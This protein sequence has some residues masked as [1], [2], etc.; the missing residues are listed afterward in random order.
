MWQ[1]LIATDCYSMVVQHVQKISAVRV[2]SEQWVSD[3]LHAVGD[4]L[5]HDKSSWCRWC[6]SGQPSVDNCCVAHPLCS[7]RRRNT[8]L[9]QQSTPRPQTQQQHLTPPTLL[10]QLLEAPTIAPRCSVN[11]AVALNRYAFKGGRPCGSVDNIV[12]KVAEYRRNKGGAELWRS[13]QERMRTS[14]PRP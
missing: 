11:M 8:L 4:A 6:L 1:E 7:P 5:A 12:G 10:H 2:H 14:L 9:L 13:P 3:Q